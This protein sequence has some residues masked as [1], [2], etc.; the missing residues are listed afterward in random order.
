MGRPA[1]PLPKARRSSRTWVVDG[2]LAAVETAFDSLTAHDDVVTEVPIGDGL[3]MALFATGYGDGGYRVHVGLD[4]DG[5][6]TR[7][8]IDFAIVH[9]AWP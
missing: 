5:K 6:P 2:N 4:A 3:D 7:F 1:S 9:L 8:V